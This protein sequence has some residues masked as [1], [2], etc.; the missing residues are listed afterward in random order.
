MLITRVGGLG[1][2]IAQQVTLAGVGHLILAHGGLLE[3]PDMNRM[4]LMDGRRI[5]EP[6]MPQ[7]VEALTRLNPGVKITPLDFHLTAS[8]TAR[9]WV[10][11]ADV[12]VS[13][14]PDFSERYAL[15]A[16]ALQ[17]GRPVIEAAMDGWMGQLTTMLPGVTAC[18][19]CRYP[20]PPPDWDPV[21][22]PVLSATSAALGCL[23]AHE[24]IRLAGGLAPVLAN[25]LMV[26]DASVMSL[27][28]YVLRK[29]PACLACGPG[30]SNL[31]KH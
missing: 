7:A 28:H 15:N 2:P 13:A 22:F 8:E 18:L 26:L 14:T 25:R 21:G 27:R 16:A 4:V 30:A 31:T 5:G 29:D 19:A 12:V 10:A 11:L 3:E 24:V 20:E 9:Q 1:G 17:V 23:A 6:R